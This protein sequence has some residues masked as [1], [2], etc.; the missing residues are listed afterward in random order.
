MKTF[1]FIK[2]VL[3]KSEP[4]PVDSSVTT[5]EPQSSNLAKTEISFPDIRVTSSGR[6]VRAKVPGT[7]PLSYTDVDNVGSNKEKKTNGPRYGKATTHVTTYKWN[8]DPLNGVGSVR[9]ESMV[10]YINDMSPEYVDFMGWE[11]EIVRSK[12]TGSIDNI[13]YSPEGIKLRNRSAVAYH[14]GLRNAKASNKPARK[15]I[16]NAVIEPVIAK[17]PKPSKHSFGNSW[18]PEEEE[19]LIEQV[20]KIGWK[21]PTWWKQVNMPGRSHKAI[22]ARYYKILPRIKQQ[23]KVTSCVD[24]NVGEDWQTNVNVKRRKNYDDV[25]IRP[26]NKKLRVLH[27]E[28]FQNAWDVLAFNLCQGK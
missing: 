14:L 9:F 8:G 1:S 3:P 7:S 11:M 12:K 18:T 26:G 10:N 28:M 24:T 13:F 5:P 25:G 22:L 21:T 15:V 23:S 27:N 19:E 4:S 20:N 16:E 6:I 17:K 2:V